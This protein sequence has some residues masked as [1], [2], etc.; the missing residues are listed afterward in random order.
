MTKRIFKT[1]LTKAVQ[2]NIISRTEVDQLISIAQ[3]FDPNGSKVGNDLLCLYRK[4]TDGRYQAQAQTIKKLSAYLDKIQ[5]TPALKEHAVQTAANIQQVEP[6]CDLV[7]TGLLQTRTFVANRGPVSGRVVASGTKVLS[8]YYEEDEFRLWD[9]ETGAIS[10]TFQSPTPWANGHTLSTDG[11]TFVTSAGD[12]GSELQIWDV[13]QERLLA[14]LPAQKGLVRYTVLSPDNRIAYSMDD[15]GR[16]CAFDIERQTKIYET[17]KPD[18]WGCDA[19]ALS[20][21]GQTIAVGTHGSR[22][23]I[24]LHAADGSEV[25]RLGPHD[26][27]VNQLTFSPDGQQLTAAP[28]GGK[29]VVW[30]ITTH[31]RAAELSDHMTNQ[32]SAVYKTVYS[33]DG[34]L[35]A[36]GAGNG[37]VHI[38]DAETNDLIS[39]YRGHRRVVTNL[40]FH[41]NGRLLATAGWDGA[42]ALIDAYTGDAVQKVEVLPEMNMRFQEYVE[43]QKDNGD[44]YRG[45]SIDKRTQYINEPNGIDF[46]GDTLVTHWKDGVIRLFEVQYA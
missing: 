42:V 21:D 28:G 35:F 18:D 39:T 36:T 38:Y 3:T 2:N 25:T 26:W 7:P 15:R 1:T 31:E 30:D 9:L 11:E 22:E 19:F 41:E 37:R 23:V 17:E 44:D 14:Q 43:D 12:E 46:S 8:R 20:P 24:L 32:Y 10:R 45:L 29:A 13:E 40:A 5:V 33:D 4:M 34:K 6:A 27:G 16:L